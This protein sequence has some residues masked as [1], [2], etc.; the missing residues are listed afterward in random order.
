MLAPIAVSSA[1]FSLGAHSA[2]ISLYVEIFC[3][4]SVLGVPG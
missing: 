4:I 3:K 1:T 2:Y